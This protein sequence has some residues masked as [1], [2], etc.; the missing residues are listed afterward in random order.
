[1]SS[2]MVNT[3]RGLPAARRIIFDVLEDR[4]DVPVHLYS[5]APAKNYGAEPLVELNTLGTTGEPDLFELRVYVTCA[6]DMVRA[7]ARVDDVV[8]AIDDA[9]PATVTALE[10]TVAY[11]QD[12]KHWRAEGRALGFR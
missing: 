9:L 7:E 1:M 6:G 11:D 2:P 12:R 4:L 5:Q 8:Q 3:R 10:W